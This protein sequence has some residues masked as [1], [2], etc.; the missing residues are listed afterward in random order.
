MNGGAGYFNRGTTLNNP[1]ANGKLSPSCARTLYV[2]V[3]KK[4]QLFYRGE[5][6]L[7]FDSCPPVLSPDSAGDPEYSMYHGNDS[8]ISSV[9]SDAF[10]R[11]TYY[12]L[13]LILIRTIRLNNEIYLKENEPCYYNPRIF[14]PS[15]FKL[16][17]PVFKK[18]HYFLEYI[19]NHF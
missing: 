9:V 10:D 17:S 1:L 14:I 12:P 3:S 2:I 13:L 16:F 4:S 8:F 7:P 18:L 11:F 5:A 19:L 6:G 15:I